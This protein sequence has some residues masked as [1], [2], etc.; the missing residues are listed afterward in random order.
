MSV[1]VHTRFLIMLVLAIV[2]WWPPLRALVRLAIHNENYS[3]TLLVLMI[4]GL[5]VCLE[6]W[7]PPSEPKWPLLVMS[8]TASGL[9]VAAWWNYRILGSEDYRLTV[10]VLFFFVFILVVFVQTY[11]GKSFPHMRFPLLFAFLA[12]PLPTAAVSWLVTGLQRG[13]AEAAYALFRLFQ[14]PI[15][16]DG[17]VFSFYNLEI[18]V[19]RECSGIR[20]STILFVTT[21]VLAKLFLESGWSMTIAVICS[22]PVAVAKNGVRIFILSLL[23][24]Y[25]SP[26]WLEGSLHQR[27][28][29]VFFAIGMAMVLAVIWLL[30]RGEEQ[31]K[32]VRDLAGQELVQSG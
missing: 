4:S 21:L 5:L 23:G 19:A 28:G 32:S 31:R 27:G 10:S 15:V 9:G 16:R 20:S 11:G 3:Y 13:S 2:A 8:L 6:H 30:R 25:V 1:R 18:E 17:L 14:V 26:S 7:S 24:E 22:L 29:V 12:V